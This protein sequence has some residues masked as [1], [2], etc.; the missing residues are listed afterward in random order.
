MNLAEEKIL[1]EVTLLS[2]SV[3]V[4]GCGLFFASLIAVGVLR[5]RNFGN[6]KAGNSLDT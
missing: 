5:F 3:R 2:W 4:N 6:C 1:W